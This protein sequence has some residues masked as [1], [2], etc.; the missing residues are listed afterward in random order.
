M[1]RVW[2]K[3]FYKIG[4]AVT[5]LVSIISIIVGSIFLLNTLGLSPELSV[6][7]SLCIT[8]VMPMLSFILYQVYNDC[9]DE[10]NQENKKIM[11]DLR[12]F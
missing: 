6:L 10:V 11:R 9:K 12:G 8:I 3:F 7:I 5:I 4:K 1:S 2:K